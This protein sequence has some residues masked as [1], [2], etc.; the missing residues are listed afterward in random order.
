MVTTSASPNPMAEPSGMTA[1]LKK[2]DIRPLAKQTRWRDNGIK[3]VR[4]L[5]RHPHILLYDHEYF[6]S[7]IREQF[8]FTILLFSQVR[9]RT[10]KTTNYTNNI[11][12]EFEN[13]RIY[14]NS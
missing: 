9:Q 8:Y 6:L 13:E 3:N 10:G 5:E 7:R 2:I 1:T 4:M 14:D 11:F 12:Q